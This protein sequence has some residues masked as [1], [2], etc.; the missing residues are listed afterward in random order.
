MTQ[1]EFDKKAT[2]LAE[3][4]M[5][6]SIGVLLLNMPFFAKAVSSLTVYAGGEGY[7]CDGKRLLYEPRLLLQRY[8]QSDRLIV[9][10]YLHMLLHC[11]FRHW[12]TGDD[13]DIYLWDAASDIA[14]EALI[15]EIDEDLFKCEN[16]RLRS[17]IIQKLSTQVRPLT[18]E[19]L[20]HY[21][22]K[23]EL[24]EEKAKEYC[25]AFFTDDHSIW[26]KNRK[27]E[28]EK[29]KQQNIIG[30]GISDDTKEQSGTENKKGDGGGTDEK[31]AKDM[32]REF[33]KSPSEKA[34]EKNDDFEKRTDMLKSSELEKLWKNISREIRTELESMKAPGSKSRF[35]TQT[36]RDLDR[37]RCDYSSF[38][39]RFMVVGE[40]MRP[41]PEN[42][43][44][45]YYSYGLALYKNVALI[46]PL[47]YKEIKRV[48]D[49][50]IAIDTSGSVSGKTVE[51]FIR[52]TYNILRSEETFFSK[53]NIH[54]IQCDTEI[55]DN[56]R[57]SSDEDL[58]EYISQ[59]Q[60]K[61]LGGTDF[62]P[63]FDYVDELL[64]KGEFTSLKGLIYFTDG[65]GEFPA[66]KPP[67]ETVFAF[68]RDDYERS[69]QPVVPPWAIK[70][71]LD[72]EELVNGK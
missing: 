60:I 69:E 72:E 43:D 24:S 22:T 52:K 14:A 68:L 7:S 13:T 33:N 58:K 41:D 51:G 55:R 19:K 18:A 42:F 64:K 53:V 56:V 36:L 21:F 61:G 65:F 29:E 50:V 5:S 25:A 63:V 45:N 8:K 4:V 26:Y 39:R 37:E 32:D 17:G 28:Y 57:I 67:Y 30:I 31:A 2:E 11:I 62:R 40:V 9:H 3:E 6:I 47:E 34:E 10:D 38:L 71:I 15:M 20:Y 12:N 27:R 44:I 49:L 48:K 66:K 54:I 16:F 35:L 46:E 59:M 70:L 23:K 1:K